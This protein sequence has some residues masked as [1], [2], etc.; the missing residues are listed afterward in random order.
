MCLYD[1]R[2][3]WKWRRQNELDRNYLNERLFKSGDDARNV[4]WIFE[5][6]LS[7]V[8]IVIIS[9]HLNFILQWNTLLFLQTQLMIWQWMNE[10]CFYRIINKYKLSLLLFKS[11][12]SALSI[13]GFRIGEQR[14]AKLFEPI[15]LNRLNISSTCAFE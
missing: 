14:R 10:M 2:E 8:T 13:W 6:D 3:V 9:L 7:V 5:I 4:K 1:T 12:F 11:N 15:Q